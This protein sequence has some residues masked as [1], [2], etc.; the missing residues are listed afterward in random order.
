MKKAAVEAIKRKFENDMFNI[1]YEMRT[2]KFKINQL[3]KRQKELK[4]IKKGL[5]EILRLINS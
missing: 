5:Y 1:N 3:A 2:N 4:D